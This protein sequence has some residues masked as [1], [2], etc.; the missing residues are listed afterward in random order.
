MDA[1]EDTR[2]KEVEGF[3]LKSVPQVSHNSAC[4]AQDK[5]PRRNSALDEMAQ[6]RSYSYYSY[7]PY[8]A[9]GGTSREGK[10]I[11]DTT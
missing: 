11:T 6:V 9:S 1:Y 2:V 10:V 3:Q 8:G 7:L 5:L 4:P